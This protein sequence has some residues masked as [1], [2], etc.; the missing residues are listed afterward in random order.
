MQVESADF[1]I[2]NVE[3]TQ[4]HS[5]QIAHALTPAVTQQPQSTT[6]RRSNVDRNFYS[7]EFEHEEV[8]EAM[9]ENGSQI[10]SVDEPWNQ[11]FEAPKRV[12]PT[13]NGLLREHTLPSVRVQE[14][15]EPGH[16]PPPFGSKGSLRERARPSARVQEL[17]EPPQS[18]NGLLRERSPPCARVQ[19]TA[20]PPQPMDEL[21]QLAAELNRR[22]GLVGQGNGLTDGRYPVQ[23]VEQGMPPAVRPH[24]NPFPMPQRSGPTDE[25]FFQR[26]VDEGTPSV[27]RPVHDPNAHFHIPSG[28]A[29]GQAYCHIH[30]LYLMEPQPTARLP[31]RLQPFTTPPELTKNSTF[32]RQGHDPR[33]TMSRNTPDRR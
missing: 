32:F 9:N 22:L 17:V 8:M 20:E 21:R 1:P 25:R 13:P 23:H 14:L 7:H 29:Y 12:Y 3:S 19:E 33:Q 28:D 4:S 15:A 16:T 27:V 30:G 6:L 10:S 26:P 11:I 31:Q 5:I 18:R 2:Q 24:P